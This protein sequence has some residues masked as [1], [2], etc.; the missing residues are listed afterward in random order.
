MNIGDAIKK[1]RKINKMTQTD[2]AIKLNKSLRTIQ[3]YESNEVTPSLQ[4]LKDIIK[5]LNAPMSEFT[6]NDY[7]KVLNQ[8]LRHFLDNYSNDELLVEH[9]KIQFS[10]DLNNEVL[11]YDKLDPKQLELLYMS[12]IRDLNLRINSLEKYVKFLED[13]N[14]EREIMISKLFSIMDGDTNGK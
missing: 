1:Y 8:T 12:R 3:K 2:L 6:E 5:A 9:N 14:K 10:E 7:N 11:I 13:V 4:V